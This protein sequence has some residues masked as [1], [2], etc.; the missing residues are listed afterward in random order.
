MHP[1]SVIS[2]KYI[3]WATFLSQIVQVI[4]NHFDVI[5]LKATKLGKITQLMAIKPFKVIQGHHFQDQL[6]ACM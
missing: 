6:K 5:G 4:C 2:Q 3:L 1:F